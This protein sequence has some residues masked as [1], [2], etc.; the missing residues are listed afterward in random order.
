MPPVVR[1]LPRGVRRGL[2]DGEAGAR[3][4]DGPAPVAVDPVE[5]APAGVVE[6]GPRPSW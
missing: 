1:D 4:E 5:A 6:V 3:L 2:W